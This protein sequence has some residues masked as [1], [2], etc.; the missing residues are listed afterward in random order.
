MKTET[1]ALLAIAPILLAI[2][3]G[4]IRLRIRVR[5]GLPARPGRTVETWLAR[6]LMFTGATVLLLYRAIAGEYAPSAVVNTVAVV[7]LVG[8]VAL[9]I[10]QWRR[11]KKARQGSS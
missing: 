3:V 2:A 6:A 5:K 10:S 8:M 1:L 4:L 7:M 11:E 9:M